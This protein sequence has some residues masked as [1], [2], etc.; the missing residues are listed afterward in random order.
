M[1]SKDSR[2]FSFDHRANGYAR[3]EGIGVLVIKPLGDAIRDGNTIRAVVR[4]TSSN[5]DGKTPGITVPSKEAQMRLILDTYAK[6]GLSLDETRY[7]EAHGTGRY[8]VS[9]PL[10]ASYG[11]KDG[12][13]GSANVTLSGTPVGDPI[14]AGA[15]GTAFRRFRSKQ[16]PLFV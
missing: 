10:L 5:Q 7:F 9:I 14:E 3:G 11:G 8:L 13:K 16:D 1:L 6:A 12:G 2:C 4:S 15:I